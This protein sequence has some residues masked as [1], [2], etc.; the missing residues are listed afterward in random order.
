MF[1]SQ[2][3]EILNVWLF[4]WFWCWELS[5]SHSKMTSKLIIYHSFFHINPNEMI[6]NFVVNLIVFFKYYIHWAIRIKMYVYKNILKD[7]WSVPKQVC[8]KSRT[9]HNFHKFLL[10]KFKL[11]LLLF[12]CDTALLYKTYFHSRF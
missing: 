7:F 9:F 4:L 5:K 6:E 2:W 12:Y 8:F 3:K 10:L 11:S 1:M